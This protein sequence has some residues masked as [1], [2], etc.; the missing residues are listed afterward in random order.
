MLSILKNLSKVCVIGSIFISSGLLAG[1][2]VIAFVQDD[3]SNDFRKAQVME[4]KIASAKYPNMKYL[5]SDAKG[6]TSLMITQFEKYMADGV[7]FIIL[8]TN[9]DR[10]LNQV[11]EKAYTKG[12]KVAILDRG[13]TTDK[14]TVFLNSDNLKIGQIGGEYV[15]KMINNKGV[16]LL[17]EGIPAADVTKDRTKGF[18][19]EMNKHKGIKVIKRVANY[20]RRD[21]IIEME[22]LLKS[23][24]K[25]DAIFGESDSMISGA[26][27][28]MIKHNIDPASIITVGC[29]YTSE[30]QKEIQ[31]GTQT[32]SVK[33]PLGTK[34]TIDTIVKILDGKKV[35]KHIV[36]P[37]ELVNKKN[38]NS[39]DPVF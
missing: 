18:M 10:A 5:Y 23:G 25:I 34:Q 26:R 19:S 4:G 21:A 1:E 33:F 29:D 28:A 36:I 13:V 30:A 11:L 31:K 8:G 15:A 39:V 22:K 27:T 9:D 7:D 16:V 35:P 3:M 24:V 12:Q 6:Q 14:Y 37:V 20:Q 38:V 32:G 17:L 2:R